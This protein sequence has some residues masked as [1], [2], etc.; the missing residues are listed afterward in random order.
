VR[1]SGG[2][3]NNGRAAVCHSAF[4]WRPLISTLATA[5]CTWVILNTAKDHK[6]T[7]FSAQVVNNWNNLPNYVVQTCS[8]DRPTFKDM[9]LTG[10]GVTNKRSK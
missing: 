8:I 3:K 10:V 9:Q 6:R 2:Y 7:T 5:S 4:L 1:L